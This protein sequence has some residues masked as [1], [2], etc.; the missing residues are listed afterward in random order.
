MHRH[1]SPGDSIYQSAL[2]I[3]CAEIDY[4]S[5]FR[6]GPL[7]Q[8]WPTASPGLM[9][10]RGVPASLGKQTRGSFRRPRL[11]PR[12][13]ITPGLPRLET[14]LLSPTNFSPVLFSLSKGSLRLQTKDTHRFL[15]AAP[16]IHL[17]SPGPNAE[18][19]SMITCRIP[20]KN[21]A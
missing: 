5:R 3:N 19:R 1:S 14:S 6:G 7:R 11:P 21:A 9:L 15:M 16:Q 18:L 13:T 20:G 2:Q 4:S 10:L 8:P 12:V 17:L